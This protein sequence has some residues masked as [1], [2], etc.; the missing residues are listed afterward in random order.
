MNSLHSAH[1]S[2][3]K[4]VVLGFESYIRSSASLT[5]ALTKHASE[6]CPYILSL[7]C[8]HALPRTRVRVHSDSHAR[9]CIIFA[10]IHTHVYTHAFTPCQLHAGTRFQCLSCLKVARNARSAS[11]SHARI[12]MHARIHSHTCAKPKQRK[13]ASF[14][15][16]TCR[17]NA[18]SASCQRRGRMRA[19]ARCADICW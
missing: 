16:T 1:S 7:A 5:P 4:A 12:H 10:L 6:F 2:I 19:Y 8:I 9:A 18:F 3:F 17:K 11:N 15:R 14:R 13:P